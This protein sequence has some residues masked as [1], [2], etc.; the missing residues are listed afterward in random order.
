MEK[1]TLEQ[2][3][4]KVSKKGK[5]IF[6]TKE[7]LD[8]LKGSKAVVVSKTFSHKDHQKLQRDCKKMSVPLLEYDGSSIELGKIVEK[9]FRISI[10]SVKS[11]GGVESKEILPSEGS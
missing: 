11:T 10:L 8:E 4:N 6:G 9:N 1:K 2:Y 7:V 3:L 5:L